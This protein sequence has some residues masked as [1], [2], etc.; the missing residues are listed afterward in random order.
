MYT[1]VHLYTEI[2]FTCTVQNC[3]KSKE[4]VTYRWMYKRSGVEVVLT[5]W[6]WSGAD[7]VLRWWCWTGVDMVLT[8]VVL[9]WCWLKWWWGR[10]EVV[11]RWWCW[12]GVDLSGVDWSGDVEVVLRWCWLKWC[13]SR[14]DWSDVEVLLRWRWF[15]FEVVLVVMFEVLLRWCWLSGDVWGGVDVVLR[16]F[17]GGVEMVLKWCWTDAEVVLI[18][19]MSSWC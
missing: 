6:C 15:D 17:W 10:A 12:S 7:V 18:K 2:T 11:L 19:I 13:W 16:W 3:M 5:W 9:R 8:D 4:I 14:V 1:F